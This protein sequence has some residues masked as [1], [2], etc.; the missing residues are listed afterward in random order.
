MLDFTTLQTKNER[1]NRICFPTAKFLEGISSVES[2]LQRSSTNR[3]KK[4][5]QPRKYPLLAQNILPAANNNNNN[6]EKAPKR[7]Q[8]NHINPKR[9]L[10]L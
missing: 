3:R 2:I 1:I 7:R 4:K 8:T 9:R 6:K 5:L 10:K